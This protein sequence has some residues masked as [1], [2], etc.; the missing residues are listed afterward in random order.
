VVRLLVASLLLTGCAS[1]PRAFSYER[2]PSAAMR[3]VWMEYA[4]LAPDDLRPDEALPLVVFLHGGGDGPDAWDRAGLGLD[5]RAG[6]ASGELPRAVIV[7]PEGDL[8][9]WANWYDGSRRYED[10]VLREVLPALARDYHT[11]PCPEGC[12]V[13]GVSMGAE[14][15]MRFAVHHPELFSTLTAI[16][17]PA[18][19]TERRLAFVDERLFQIFI[20]TY[21][22]FGPPTPRSRVERDDPFLRWR[23]PED[24]SGLRIFLAWGSRDR[25]EVRDGSR[26]LHAHLSEHAIPHTS[27]EYEGEHAWR[28]WRAVIVRALREQLVR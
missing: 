18:L 10:F 12:H 3:G 24:V 22:V 20:P 28:D 27:L 4:V 15:A 6:W 23:S 1:F 14:G 26:A 16:S 7:L 8:G 19:D 25:G 9:F 17:G 5:V 13:M 11:Q 2:A 21:H